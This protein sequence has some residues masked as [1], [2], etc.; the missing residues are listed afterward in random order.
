MK[1]TYLFLVNCLVEY[2]NLWGDDKRIVVLLGMV[3][4]TCLNCHQRP[5]VCPRLRSFRL[6]MG[7]IL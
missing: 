7:L 4:C 2:N 3:R 1:Q 6:I 5:K